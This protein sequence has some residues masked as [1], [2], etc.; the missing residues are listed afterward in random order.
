ME[1]ETLSMTDLI[2]LQSQLGEVL[3]RR[4]ERSLAL[5]FTDV[6]GSTAYFARHGDAAGRALQQRHFDLLHRSFEG[7]AGRVVDTAGDGAFSCFGSLADAA[8][9]MLRLLQ[10][11]TTESAHYPDE[12]RL[13]VRIGLHW[14]RALT[15]GVHVSGDAV[16]LCARVA[17]AG[18]PG[19]ILVTRESFVQLPPEMRLLC[20][21]RA[22][23]TLKGIAE[24]VELWVL[25]PRATKRATHVVLRPPGQRI[26]LPDKEMIAFGRLEQ[27]EG[28]AA[29]DIVL[30]VSDPEQA[31]LI[32]RWH[33]E[34]HANHDE[35]MLRALT[36]QGTVVD[37]VEVPKGG[38][39][40]VR[41]GSVVDVAGVVQ[42]TF[43]VD[44]HGGSDATMTR[45]SAVP[46]LPDRGR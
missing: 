43:S 30:K 45:P 46:N 7:L 34:L 9:A 39:A 31:R 32:S 23:A 22:P 33:F 16:N 29:N 27:H 42:L 15:D 3:R 25:K 40:R 4:F 36:D 38:H 20:A 35:H 28:R 10:S 17:S 12:H 37:G 44:D 5:C 13:T 21:A 2:R 1:L 11:I 18:A 41:P 6:V 8:H 24:P 14:G 26:A 19:E